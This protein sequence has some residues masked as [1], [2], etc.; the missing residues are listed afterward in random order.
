MEKKSEFG[1]GFI[2]CLINFAKHLDMAFSQL[3]SLEGKMEE[4]RILSSWINSASDHLFELEL[5]KNLPEEIKTAIEELRSVAIDYGHGSKMMTQFPIKE[6]DKMREGL[7]KI[8]VMID[9]WLGV[10]SIPAS[11]D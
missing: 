7:N 9:K 2:C 11:W 5:P 4:D 3:G 10:K 1:K 8:A 6:Y